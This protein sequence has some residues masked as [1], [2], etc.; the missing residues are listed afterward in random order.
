[1]ASRSLVIIVS[2]YDWSLVCLQHLGLYIVV[3]NPYSCDQPI[4]SNYYIVHFSIPKVLSLCIPG[5][6]QIVVT[7]NYI[8]SFWNLQK[9]FWVCANY[10][11]TRANQF[12][13]TL[14]VL[15]MLQVF[16]L[17]VLILDVF[18]NLLL[19]GRLCLLKIFLSIHYPSV[20]KNILIRYELIP[21]GCLHS[22]GCFALLLFILQDILLSTNLDAG[23]R[24]IGSL[25]AG[26]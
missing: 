20:G 13:E 25:T 11:F 21:L 24:N 19:F 23:C 14:L 4:Q 17:R 15:N 12:L 2:L 16:L 22:L 5:W 10:I 18:L 6:L 26:I 9:V 3:T 7:Y 1:M 8:N